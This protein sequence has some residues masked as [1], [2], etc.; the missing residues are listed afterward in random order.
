MANLPIQSFNQTVT[1]TVI[2]MQGRNSKLINFATGSVLRA[3]AEGFGATFMWF[4]ALVLQLLKAMRLSTAKDDDVDTFTAD[5]MPVR[6]NSQTAT[7]PNGTP[8]LGAQASTGQVVFSRFTAAPS[9]CFVPVGA[10]AKTNDGKNVSFT[11]ISDPSNAYYSAVLGGYTLPSSVGSFSLPVQ[12]ATPGAIGNVKAGAISI[13]SS[14]LTGIDTVTNIADFINGFDKEQDDSLKARFHAYI[15]GLSRGDLFGLNASVLGVEPEVQYAVT[16][17]YNYDGSYRPG[18]FFVVAD[19]G[20][21]NP[22]QSFLNA[23]NLAAQAVRPLAIQCAVFA[24]VVLLANVSMIIGTAPTFDHNTVSAEVAAAVATQINSLGLGVTLQWSQI[25][26]WAYAVPGV[27][28]V[29]A[30]EINGVFGDGASLVC[31]QTTQDGTLNYVTATV[32][33]NEVIVS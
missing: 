16:E 23:I 3:I 25:A 19:D 6:P 18:F 1:N 26:S 2:G 10:Q 29:T 8:R 9:T 7:L 30:V 4:Q 31:T 28:S 14:S 33:A 13:I 27:V 22:P 5:F 17:G 11:V 20:S 32:K 15:L 12:C 21:G 24:P